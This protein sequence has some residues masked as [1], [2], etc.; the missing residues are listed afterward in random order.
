MHGAKSDNHY[1]RTSIGII[2]GY[3]LFIS[4]IPPPITSFSSL[5]N[6][7]AEK[8]AL[9]LRLMQFCSFNISLFHFYQ[10]QSTTPPPHLPIFFCIIYTGII[11]TYFKQ[12]RLIED[13]CACFGLTHH[14]VFGL[15]PHCHVKLSENCYLLSSVIKCM[16]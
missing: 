4:I 12:V 5:A 15:L 13:E 9:V 1:K 16:S 14:C 11:L 10:K 2:Q 6:T 3:L 7:N 8:N